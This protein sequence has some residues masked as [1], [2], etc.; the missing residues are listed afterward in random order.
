MKKRIL[1]ITRVLVLCAFVLQLSAQSDV[2]EQFTYL[3]PHP[4]AQFANVEHTLSFRQGDVLDA[5]T[6]VSSQLIV[7]GSAS[8]VH[9]GTLSLSSDGRTLIFT[10]D[11]PFY[12]NE[13]VT[14]QVLEGFRTIN[15]TSIEP[16]S[17]AFRTEKQDNRALNQQFVEH[18]RKE[19]NNRQ[20][21]KSVSKVSPVTGYK[22]S[23][24]VPG[25][26]PELM[27]KQYNNPAP[28][29]IF[30]NPHNVLHPLSDPSYSV[31]MDHYGTP[32]WYRLHNTHSLDVKIQETGHVSEFLAESAAGLGIGYGYHIIYDSF[33][34]PIDTFQMGNG[35]IAEMHDFQY[36]ND[37][38][39][40]MFTYDGQIIDMSQIVEGGDPAAT[41]M[42]FVLQE[43]DESKNVVFEWSSWDHMSITDATPD[44]DLTGVFIDYCH[45]NAVERDD[46]GNLLVSF[47]NTD[48]IIKINRETGEIMWRM[49]A[50]YDELNDITFLNDTIKFSHQHDIRRQ[51][52][53]NITIFDNGNLHWGPYSRILEYSLDEE[54]KTAE[55]VYVYP[56]VPD[57]NHHFAFATGGAHWQP[58]GNVTVGWGVQFP[59]PDTALIIGE[60]TPDAESV[61]QV[62]ATDSITTYRAHKFMWE[63]DL[64]T[65]SKDTIDWGEFTGYTPAPYI[66][67]ITNNS[68]NTI[69]LSGTHNRTQQYS[70]ISSFPMDVEPGNTANVTINFFPSTDGYF[71]DVLTVMCTKSEHEMIAQQVVLTGY[72]QDQSAPVAVFEPEDN[73]TEIELMPMLKLTFNEKLYINGGEPLTNAD[74]GELLMLDKYEKGGDAVAFKAWLTWYSTERTEIMVQP[75]DY[76]EANTTYAWGILGGMVHDWNGNAIESDLTASFTTGDEMNVEDILVN[77]FARLF[78]N[79]TSGVL[80]LEFKNNDRKSVRIFDA[81]GE[82]VLRAENLVGMNY[83]FNISDQPKGIFIVQV[84]NHKTDRSVEL[85]VIKN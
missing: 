20:P 75:F 50:F 44:I 38:S 82:E 67:Q 54:N 58:N 7:T 63:T 83:T 19:M 37:G 45:G 36:F 56:P 34:N 59:I 26:F 17:Y 71:E 15:G 78:P 27:I 43:L 18:V 80:S 48:E 25:D 70:V 21:H 24:P 72:T 29:Y 2:A 73:A 39:C 55:L 9:S 77:D 6:L 85:K 14:V 74:L 49:N 57:T 52:N 41:V 61:Y 62:W 68:E 81:N 31:I 76:L 69:T 65:L 13:S 46:D 32:V 16:T 1:Q 60:V 51:D 23:A 10:P 35:Y 33:M 5:S 79:P 53:G 8:G 30:M 4:G 12:Y 40:L 84:I 28:G 3:S 64:F 47:R 42:G 11:Q 22:S 66:L